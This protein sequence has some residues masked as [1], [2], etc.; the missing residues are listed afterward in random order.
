MIYFT[1]VH[2]DKEVHMQ[3]LGFTKRVMLFCWGTTAKAAEDAA[4]AYC[5]GLGQT[6][7]RT[8]AA[9]PAHQQNPRRYTFP[10]QIIDLPD[11]LTRDA[12]TSRGYPDSMVA[13]TLA[14][15]AKRQEA[16]RVGRER[17]CATA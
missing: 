4:T 1:T 14:T 2:L 3:A 16:L 9:R 10:E 15:L 12:I 13:D 8:E 6:P 11:E 7:T 17:L 5:V